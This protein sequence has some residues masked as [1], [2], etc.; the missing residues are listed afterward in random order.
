MV[1]LKSED[2]VSLVVN[3]ED[4]GAARAVGKSDDGFE[5]GLTFRREVLLKFHGTTFAEVDQVTEAD[6]HSGQEKMVSEWYQAKSARTKRHGL[7]REEKKIGSG[8]TALQT[9]Q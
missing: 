1:G 3:P 2:G 9:A 8:V 4:E 6:R 5:V 7:Q